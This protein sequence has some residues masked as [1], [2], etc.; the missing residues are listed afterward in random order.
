[1]QTLPSGSRWLHINIDLAVLQA[2]AG[3]P[4]GCASC[5]CWWWRKVV[6]PCLRGTAVQH[7][8][9]FAW[10]QLHCIKSATLLSSDIPASWPRGSALQPSLYRR[11]H[12]AAAVL[13]CAQAKCG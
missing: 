6:H 11:V 5:S 1:V 8:L 9:V 3:Y 13:R 10:E 2:M 7:Q 12:V 4:T